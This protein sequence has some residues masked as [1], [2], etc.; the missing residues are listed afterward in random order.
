MTYPGGKQAAGTYQ[1][2]I[3]LMPPHDVYIEP[4]LGSGAVM[5]MKRPAAIN[6]G[7]DLDRKALDA[8]LELAPPEMAMQAFIA[9][10][11]ER[12]PSLLSQVA[13]GVHRHH[14]RYPPTHTVRNDDEALSAGN[15]DTA[16]TTIICGDAFEFLTTYPFTGRELVYCDPPYPHETRSRDNYYRYE[17]GTD[18]HTRLLIILKSLPCMVMI[19]SYESRLYAHMLK[20]WKSTSFQAMT[21]GGRMATE[22]LWYNYPEPIELHDWRYLG[23]DFRERE[24]IKRKKQRWVNRLQAMPTLE[25]RALLAALCEACPELEPGRAGFGESLP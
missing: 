20:S 8:F 24:R 6:I 9:G 2:I 1:T 5:R 15:G 4:F 10:T 16:G 17:M 3:N 19:S 12:D 21:R 25:R 18:N 22:C 23:G 14:G 7:V 11:D 13:A